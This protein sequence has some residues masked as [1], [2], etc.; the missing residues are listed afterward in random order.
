MD[1]PAGAEAPP[2]LPRATIQLLQAQG[3]TLDE[4]TSLTA[5]LCGLPTAGLDWS[6][7]QICQMFFLQRLYQL[8]YF[9]IEDGERTK[10]H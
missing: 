2:R 7:R 8:G 5:F 3:L 9:G 10:P 4:A 6:L 1:S